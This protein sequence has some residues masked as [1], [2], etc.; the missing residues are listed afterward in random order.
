MS[1]LVHAVHS[2]DSH[3]F[4]QH[5]IASCCLVSLSLNGQYH[6]TSHSVI[7]CYTCSPLLMFMA[8]EHPLGILQM[9]SGTFLWSLSWNLI[10][11][12]WNLHFI[13]VAMHYELIQLATT[14]KLA[15]NM[16]CH[17]SLFCICLCFLPS[18]V[19]H[20]WIIVFSCKQGALC[21]GLLLFCFRVTFHK[22][23]RE[24]WVQS[25]CNSD[26]WVVIPRIPLLLL[27]YS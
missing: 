3:S 27:L 21:Y 18:D 12:R 2:T 19:S 20:P 10:A 17:A 9:I 26:S 22:T 6:Q 14:W 7:F 24:D 11:S 8:V 13:L 16:L 23:N 5:N 15:T 4:L 1:Y 25:W